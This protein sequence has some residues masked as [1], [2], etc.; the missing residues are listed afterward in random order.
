[1][2]YIEKCAFSTS[3]VFVILI[4]GLS[5][6]HGHQHNVTDIYRGYLESLNG[7]LDDGVSPCDNF[8]LHVCGQMSTEE[9]QNEIQE[10]PPFLYNHQDFYE[11]FEAHKSDFVTKPG[12]LVRELYD[13]C[14]LT[15]SQKNSPRRVWMRMITEIPF[16]KHDND[17]LRKWPFLQYQWHTYEPELDLNWPTLAAEFSAHGF[18]IFFNI[19]FAE[20]TI[21]ITPNRD[22]LCPDLRE[23][24]RT[25]IPLLK[26]RSV[27]IA[28]IIGR[29]MW[30]LCRQLKG[31]LPV[32]QEINEVSD[33]LLDETMTEFLQRYFPRL[34]LTD[35]DI[36]QARK[37]VVDVE[38]LTEMMSVLKS[39]NPR[40]VYNFILWHV[41]QQLSGLDDCF[42]L[43]DEFSNMLQVEYWHWNV[44]D[45][46]FRREVALA[47]YLFHTTRF[48][49][50]YRQAI[51]SSSLDRM[52]QD[53]SQRK[54]LNIEKSIRNFAKQYLSPD[55]YT[56]IYQ[57]EL[58][59]PNRTFYT[60]LLEMR[61]L[62]LRYSFYNS[63]MDK[64]DLNFFREFIN[65]CILLQYRPRF[66]YFASYD[67]EMW[68]DSKVLHSSDGLYT[69]MD[70]LEQQ[71]RLNAY[72]YSELFEILAMDQIH[73]IF[74]FYTSFIEAVADYKFWLESENF[75]LAE[76]FILEYFDLDSS[77]IMFYAV[78]QQLC[79]RNDRVYSTIINR[80]FMNIPEFQEAFEC[81]N[82]D[83]MNPVTKCRFK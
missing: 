40:I 37:I 4:I 70:C 24:K 15:Q 3:F 71:T 79:S 67:R 56:A 76:D 10:I 39:T 13:L 83:A 75:S 80:A 46:H 55:N 58:Q 68:R 62:S 31:E 16:L 59:H 49:R 6:I 22:F 78:A 28:D 42:S 50:Y 33:F 34:N 9:S 63:Y 7:Y 20:N 17:L 44:F 35:V 1:M 65:F 23:F 32:S 38:V 25:L 8:F 77:R 12:I 57:I 47:M 5:G 61:R 54:E 72:D 36:E 27:Q 51:T 74:H 11:F 14:K 30:Q 21:Y 60:S 48:Q 52:F 29:E 41:F 43:T 64:E 45:D 82:L 73:E 19:F 18:E 81:S 53:R 69:A 66:H 2:D 26:Q